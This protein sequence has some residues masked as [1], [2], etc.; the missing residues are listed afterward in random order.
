V[1]VNHLRL[2]ES[3][4]ASLAE[5]R[6]CARGHFDSPWNSFQGIIQTA[7]LAPQRKA[8]GNSAGFDRNASREAP[9]ALV[10]YS[11]EMRPR[12]KTSLNATLEL[13]QNRRVTALRTFP[14]HRAY[15]KALNG[16]APEKIVFSP[17]TLSGWGGGR[18]EQWDRWSAESELAAMLNVPLVVNGPP[19]AAPQRF[20]TNSRP[21]T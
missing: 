12:P 14:L 3:F 8:R 1:D 20:A 19:D 15:R 18:E 16:P 2:K 13:E 9:R 4:S 17:G 7:A 5:A 6:R 10:F 21:R 11:C